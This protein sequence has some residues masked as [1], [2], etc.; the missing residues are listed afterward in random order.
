MLF[1]LRRRIV[2]ISICRGG[3]PD[4]VEYLTVFR[5]AYNRS[6]FGRPTSVFLCFSP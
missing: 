2:R 1:S 6:M 4:T 5:E 3:T